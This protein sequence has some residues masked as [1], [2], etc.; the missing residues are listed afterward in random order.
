MPVDAWRDRGACVG[1][2]RSA[3]TVWPCDEEECYMTY[4]PFGTVRELCGKAVVNSVTL[5]RPLR[6]GLHVAP[7]ERRRRNPQKRYGRLPRAHAGQRRDIKPMERISPVTSG[8]V[9]PSPPL[10]YHPGHCSTI[11]G[12]VGAPDDKTSPHPLLYILRPSVS[13]TLESA[14][15][16]RPN[17]KLPHSHPRR[18][19]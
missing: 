12:A 1:K 13:C 7:L 10:C 17:G 9:R 14:Y 19:S 15:R 11:P 5:S 6:Y 3:A 2:T 4:L 8:P 16:R 18:R